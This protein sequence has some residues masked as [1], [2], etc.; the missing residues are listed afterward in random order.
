MDWAI[1]ISAGALG[2]SALALAK[3]TSLKS[4]DLRIETKCAKDEFELAVDRLDSISKEAE[5][6]RPRVASAIGSLQSGMMVRWKQNIENREKRATAL[7]GQFAVR[8]LNYDSMSPK[9]LERALVELRRLIGRAK[10]IIGEYERDLAWDDEQRRQI[11][12]D[13]RAN[14]PSRK[15][16]FDS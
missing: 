9:K 10:D 13:I 15:S 6:S 5:K 11:R 12:E 16:S 1:L 2:I 8:Q 14:P 3:V 4:L 7:R